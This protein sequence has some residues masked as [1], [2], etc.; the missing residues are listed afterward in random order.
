M[1]LSVGTNLFGTKDQIEECANIA[2]K[3]NMWV[4]IEGGVFEKGICFENID[5]L[6]ISMDKLF[7]VP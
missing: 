1:N 3:F 4:H 5:S 7:S 2:K 6:S